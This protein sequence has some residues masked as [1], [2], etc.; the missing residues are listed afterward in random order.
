MT[1]T[2]LLT[3]FLHLTPSPLPICNLTFF[4]YNN[5]TDMAFTSCLSTLQSKLCVLLKT[6]WFEMCLFLY[7]KKQL[8]LFYLNCFVLSCN[9]CPNKSVKA[10]YPPPPTHTHTHPSYTFH[11]EAKTLPHPLV[12]CKNLFERPVKPP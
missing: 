11:T 5:D 4:A 12:K 7:V 2:P 9:F 3:I 1:T 6:C 8:P 10:K